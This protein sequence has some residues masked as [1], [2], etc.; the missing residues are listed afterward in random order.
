[1]SWER[2]V[3]HDAQD[4]DLLPVMSVE[5]S[6]WRLDNLSIPPSLEFARF[7]TA[8]GISSK[9]LDAPEYAPDESLCRI[10]IVEGN[11][12]SDGVE[13][14]E[15]GFRPDYLSHRAIRCFALA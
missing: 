4:V 5:N 12:I 9:V 14:G 3:P 13:I 11:V 7:G 6:T 2:L 15:R 1:M 10:R 8:L